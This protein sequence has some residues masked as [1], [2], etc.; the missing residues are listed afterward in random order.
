MANRIPKGQRDHCKENSKKTKES[1]QR[2][3]HGYK[4]IMANRIPKGERDHCK[5][6]S[7]R[8]KDSWQTEFHED[9]GIIANRIPRGSTWLS[10]CWIFDSPRGKTSQKEKL[11]SPPSCCC[12]LQLHRL[13]SD[14]K[15]PNLQNVGLCREQ[16]RGQSRELSWDVLLLLLRGHSFPH[17]L[18]AALRPWHSTHGARGNSW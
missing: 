11:S 9:K 5:E 15:L 2:E 3:F 18:Q 13:N 6:N 16:Q 10:L 17:T 1:Q 4:W 8:T 7:K 14:G 12:S